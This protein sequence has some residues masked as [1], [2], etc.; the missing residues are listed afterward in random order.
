MGGY[1]RRNYPLS[2]AVR[3]G[4]TRPAVAALAAALMLTSTVGWAAAY[5]WVDE[6]GK[7]HYSDIPPTSNGRGYVELSAQGRTV[8]QVESAEAR[9]RRAAEAGRLAE[10]DRRKR[11]RAQQDA[12]LLATYRSAAEIEVAKQRALN[13]ERELLDNLHARRKLSQTKGEA[14][15]LD[16]QIV[17]RTQNMATVRARFD[18]D[19]ARYIELTGKR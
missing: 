12:A 3:R 16:E 8:R 17:L 15:Y 4:L 7:V 19:K 1:A 13:I 2:P 5:R 10:E 14:R 11:E 9:A 6:K 18:T